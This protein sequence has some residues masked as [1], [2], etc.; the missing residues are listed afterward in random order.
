LKVLAQRAVANGK[1]E[2]TFTL[3]PTMKN[4]AAKGQPKNWVTD[5]G[6]DCK[7]ILKI[8][9]GYPRSAEYSKNI[10][11][12]VEHGAAI[13]RGLKAIE[14]K[15]LNFSRAKETHVEKIGA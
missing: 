4:D 11:L 15:G 9:G 10:K 2:I 13:L 12:V 14:A 7:V 5:E 3:K 1:G 8:D 6:K